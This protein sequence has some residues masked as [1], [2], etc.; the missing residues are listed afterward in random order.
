MSLSF[1]NEN[2]RIQTLNKAHLP[3]PAKLMPIPLQDMEPRTWD[4]T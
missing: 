2:D 4:I 3:Q 1:L